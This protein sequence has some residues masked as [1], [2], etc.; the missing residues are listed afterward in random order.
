MDWF[1]L[2]DTPYLYQNRANT[3]EK[4]THQYHM[5]EIYQRAGQIYQQLM[6]NPP[7]KV[8]DICKGCV[9]KLKIKLLS[10]FLNIDKN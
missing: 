8:K 2:N 9:V 3:L 10:N 7:K 5:Q 6:K 4:I 1:M